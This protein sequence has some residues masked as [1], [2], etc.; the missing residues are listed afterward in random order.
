VLVGRTQAK[1]AKV[2]EGLDQER[3][4]V[5]AADVAKPENVDLVIS[6]T[7]K[8]FGGIDVLVNNAAVVGIGGFLDKSVADW[9][10]LMSVNLTGVFYLIRTA[11]PH[12]LKTKGNI[13]NVSSIAGLGGEAGNSFYAAAKAAVNNLTQ[14]LALELGRT[15]VRVNCV[16]P[17]LT[18][19]DMTATLF[20]PNSPHKQLGDE[21]V[22]RIPL[23][24]VGQPEEI[25]AAI[26]FFASA[27][28]SF[29]NGA[30]LPVDGGTTA[31]NGQIRWGV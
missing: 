23:G 5:Q 7:V 29:I 4:L 16:C 28:A 11:L 31:S 27:E 10:E 17:G 30:N 20:D 1:L 9:H 14:S 24:R 26:A 6:N 22:D 21:A 2:A 19:T 18:V 25:A 3:C 15:G 12:L 13:V 8:R